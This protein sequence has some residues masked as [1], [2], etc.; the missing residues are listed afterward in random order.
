MERKHDTATNLEK[1]T[2]HTNTCDVAMSISTFE[3]ITLSGVT[4]VAKETL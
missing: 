1:L 4:F 3:E 2:S